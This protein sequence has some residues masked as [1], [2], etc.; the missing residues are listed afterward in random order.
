MARPPAC[1]VVVAEVHVFPLEVVDVL[2]FYPAPVAAV[3]R[4]DHN[5]PAVE[6]A[7]AEEDTLAFG[8]DT[9]LRA[10]LV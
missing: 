8:L 3:H 6:A 2:I 10:A 1:P 7:D 9:Q 4:V 5:L